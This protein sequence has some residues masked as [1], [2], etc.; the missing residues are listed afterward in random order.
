MLRDGSVVFPPQEILRLAGIGL[1][2]RGP[3]VSPFGVAER[4]ENQAVVTCEK[5]SHLPAPV[6]ARKRGVFLNRLEHG[7]VMRS[8]L[9]AMHV[10]DGEECLGPCLV[11]GQAVELSVKMVV[12]DESRD[13]AC[14]RKDSDVRV[15]RVEPCGDERHV[16][17]KK[18]VTIGGV[19]RE[20][21]LS[22]RLDGE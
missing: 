12:R 9:E 6:A 20:T 22:K 10:H 19:V 21:P 1:E 16:V 4:V 7:V 5:P 2:K 17:V 11:V 3:G 18:R 14:R 15:G 13:Q 8:G